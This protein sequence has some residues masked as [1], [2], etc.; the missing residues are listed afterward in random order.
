MIWKYEKERK[1]KIKVRSGAYREGLG[2]W[3]LIP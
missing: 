3:T 1:M 2:L